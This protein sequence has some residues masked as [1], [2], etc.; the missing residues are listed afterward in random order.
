MMDRGFNFMIPKAK[1]VDSK[2][3][4]VI[5]FTLFKREFN[6]SFKVKRTE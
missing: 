6:L 4:Y 5:R 2:F 3:D 1:E